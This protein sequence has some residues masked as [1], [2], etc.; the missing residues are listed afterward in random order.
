M[1]PDD[2]GMR[3]T[4]QNR[5]NE[6]DTRPGHRAGEQPH[7][8]LR[9]TIF[10]RLDVDSDTRCRIS[11]M[12]EALGNDGGGPVGGR[13]AG[14]SR[15][16]LAL[17]NRLRQAWTT[18]F[19]MVQAGNDAMLKRHRFA[20]SFDLSIHRGS[21]EWDA[22]MRDLARIGNDIFRAIFLTGEP[23]L[24]AAGRRLVEILMS[25]PQVVSIHSDDVFV[26]WHMLYVPP[27]GGTMVADDCPWSFEGFLGY[28]HHLEHVFSDR[29]DSFRHR[30][31][32]TGGI[33]AGLNVDTAIDEMDPPV[34]EPLRALLSRQPTERIQPCWR[35]D[36]AALDS[37]LRD[38]DFNDQIM[39]FNCHGTV[40][41]A[42]HDQPF[43]ALTD[44][45]EIYTSHFE[46]WLTG[47]PLT[48]SPIVVVNACEGGQLSSMYLDSFGLAL[49][50][51][52]AN[53]LIGPQ[54]E[55]PASFAGKYAAEFF[56][57][58][59]R[60]V[61]VGDV[62][63]GLARGFA[64]HHANPLG[65]TISQYR[66]LDTYFDVSNSDDPDPTTQRV[67]LVRDDPVERQRAPA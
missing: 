24:A 10:I 2:L 62:V 60:G 64:E 8:P 53:C 3:R 27:D 29:P 50:N 35:A 46:E 28:Q 67:L 37:A 16:L 23:R 11:L 48:H 42:G 26:P 38:Q 36:F 9:R 1:I 34:I 49:L 30:L 58:L 66:G 12:G 43:I 33:R 7:V 25:G 44:R 59:L 55:I 22:A 57:E 13:T 15:R 20:A 40:D 5:L 61:P 4:V 54:I 31:D 21:P 52:E 63:R 32:T 51:A 47:R 65:L 45:R 18:K 6:P 56:R 41:P 39:Y 14:N 17:V 19:L